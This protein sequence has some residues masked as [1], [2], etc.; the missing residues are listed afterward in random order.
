MFT[1]SVAYYDAIFRAKGKDYADEANKLRAIIRRYKRSSGT[2]LLDV[3]CGDG[4][5]IP[6]LK[7]VYKI[8]GLD[9]DPNM[10]A[11]ARE[12]YPALAF[13]QGNMVDFHL[14]QLFDIVMCLTSAIGYA[15]TLDGMYRTI[16]TMSEHV[17]PGG[18]VILEPW[19]SPDEYRP[20]AVFAVFVDEPDLKIAR[21]NTNVLR[22]SV[23]VL[24][25]HYLVGTPE[26]VEHVTELHE[27]GLFTQEQYYDAFQACGL[28]THHEKEGLIGRGIFIGVK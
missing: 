11:M 21:I 18:L 5:H 10:L 9:L 3:A 19:L 4:N 6:Y 23:S 27:L 26:G 25:F 22:D 2:A 17:L 7:D 28:T 14:A 16:R 15:K 20:G 12:R 24:H 8:T 13:H 1:K